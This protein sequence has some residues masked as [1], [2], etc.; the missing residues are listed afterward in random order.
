MEG[1][2]WFVY[3]ALLAAETFCKLE[4]IQK[5]FQIVQEIEINEKIIP[6]KL[7]GSVFALRFKLLVLNDDLDKASELLKESIN[8]GDIVNKYANFYFNLSKV[9]FYISNY[10]TSKAISLL[11]ELSV[12]AKKNNANE[13]LIEI[14]LLK[15]RSYFRDSNKTDAINSVISALFLAQEEAFIRIFLSEGEDI[16]TMIKEIHQEKL[17]KT[18]NSLD[19][20]SKKY[21][22]KLILAYGCDAEQKTNAVDNIIS[23][24]ELDTLKLIA[25]NFTNQEIANRLFISLNTVKT[26]LKNI[27]I[28]LEANNR[29]E[30]VTRAKEIG[31]L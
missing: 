31:V 22:E 5:A 29:T 17:T 10:N 28:K 13:M 15:A 26:H 20:V 21:L 30:A 27:N 6:Q 7:S 9:R 24:R 19:L 14:E 16:K 4:D 11:N 1:G 12:I 8:R 25:E 18:S 3:C 2:T 23:K